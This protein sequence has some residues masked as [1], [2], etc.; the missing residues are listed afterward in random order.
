[1]G[2]TDG[3]S[4]GAGG[5]EGSGRCCWPVGPFGRCWSPRTLKVLTIRVFPLSDTKLPW[6]GIHLSLGSLLKGGTVTEGAAR[7]GT[8]RRGDRGESLL[9]TIN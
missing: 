6:A 1:M 4:L 5:V 2:W 3:S 7:G 8:G 9:N